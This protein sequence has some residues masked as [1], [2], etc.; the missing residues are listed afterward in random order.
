MD[1]TTDAL[2][3]DVEAVVRRFNDAWNAHDLA[4]ALSM[5]SDDCIFESTSP[6][7]GVRS[8]G[9]EAIAEAWRPIF[10]D[11]TSRF[12]T[13]DLFVAGERVVQRWRYHWDGG[14]VRGVDLITVRDGLVTQKLSYVKG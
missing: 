8:T 11:R 4:T 5:I 2:E 9:R 14:H 12:T 6:P 7:D 13:E 1:D 3:R 10:A